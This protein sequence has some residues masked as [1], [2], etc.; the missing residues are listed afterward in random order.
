MK[1]EIALETLKFIADGVSPY[2]RRALR[3]GDIFHEPEVLEAVN[4]AIN[5]I[6]QNIRGKSYSTPQDKV[7]INI[8]NGKARN[9]G[10]PWSNT[11]TKKLINDYTAGRPVPRLSREFGRSKG[12]I[13][14]QLERHDV[15]IR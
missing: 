5:L 4:V 15:T 3:K 9:H 7:L 1:T 8:V 2:S 10:L 14:C 12:A 11:D 6:A 13:I